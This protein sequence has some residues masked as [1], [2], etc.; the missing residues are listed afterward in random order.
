[1]TDDQRTAAM[2]GDP[3]IQITGHRDAA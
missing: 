2:Y 3:T 1:L